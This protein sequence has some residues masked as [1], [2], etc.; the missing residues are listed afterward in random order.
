MRLNGF[1]IEYHQTKKIGK[2]VLCRKEKL[3]K[4]SD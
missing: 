4:D 2:G 1:R 3:I